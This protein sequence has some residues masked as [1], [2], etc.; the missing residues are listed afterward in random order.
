MSKLHKH[1]SLPPK[2]SDERVDVENELVHAA[3]ER[4]LDEETSAKAR[5]LAELEAKLA[6]TLEEQAKLEHIFTTGDTSKLDLEH[7]FELTVQATPGPGG[8]LPCRVGI[9]GMYYNIPRE[10]PVVVPKKVIEVL[11][12][13]KYDQ[14]EKM[15]GP[16]GNPINVRNTYHR[17]PYMARPLF[18]SSAKDRMM[19]GRINV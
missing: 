9:N 18:D 8:S 13:A 12:V 5:Q 6:Y 4:E 15:V 2:H 11:K 3:L 14:W 7:P 19:E 10:E 16:D 17:Y 1:P